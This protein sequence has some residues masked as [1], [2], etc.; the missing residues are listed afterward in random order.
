MMGKNCQKCNY[1]KQELERLLIVATVLLILFVAAML[2]I[3]LYFAAA[4]LMAEFPH[5]TSLL[6]VVWF[7]YAFLKDI[8]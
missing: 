7:C 8:V 4:W 3:G 6:L 5:A 2:L 1:M